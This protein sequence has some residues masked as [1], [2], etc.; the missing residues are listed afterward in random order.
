MKTILKKSVVILGVVS[1]L[2]LTACSGSNPLEKESPKDVNA[3]LKEASAYAELNVDFNLH[4]RQ[5][6]M[7]LTCMSGLK[8]P[9]KG[10]PDFC[11][12]LYKDMVKYANKTDGP[13]SQLT[14]KQLTNQELFKQRQEDANKHFFSAS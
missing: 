9:I 4:D 7:Y 14:V 11:P 12:T 6:Y 8:K 3:F 1:A 10:H 2:A 13:F 5:G